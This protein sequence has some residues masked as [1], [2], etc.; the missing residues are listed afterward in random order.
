[1][2]ALFILS[3]KPIGRADEDHGSHQNVNSD[4]LG[5]AAPFYHPSNS[6]DG[7]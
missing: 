7:T 6:L 1:M 2:D 4:L 3:W 5:S